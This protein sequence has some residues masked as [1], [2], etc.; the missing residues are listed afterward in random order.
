MNHEPHGPEMW[1][2]GWRLRKAC[3][4]RLWRERKPNLSEPVKCCEHFAGAVVHQTILVRHAIQSVDARRGGALEVK[5]TPAQCYEHLA[6]YEGAMFQ[7]VCL[8]GPIPRQCLHYDC[9]RP[10]WCVWSDEEKRWLRDL[11]ARHV[12]R[13]ICLK[14]SGPMLGLSFD[15]EQGCCRASAFMGVRDTAVCLKLLSSLSENPS[16]KLLG[17]S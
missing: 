12:P 4:G 16:M 10:P 17:V 6:G 9:N 14:G 8:A 15:A 11:A 5:K 13:G 2:S 3:V 7:R 1:P